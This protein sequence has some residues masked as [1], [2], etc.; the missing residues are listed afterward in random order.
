MGRF[1][2]EFRATDE[3]VAALA[4]LSGHWIGGVHHCRPPKLIILDMDASETPTYGN[5]EGGAYSQRDRDLRLG[6]AFVTNRSLAARCGR[7]AP[8]KNR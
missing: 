5:R 2:T 3:N 6:L 4:G 7:S 1:E 8:A